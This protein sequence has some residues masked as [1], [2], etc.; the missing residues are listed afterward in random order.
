M[1]SSE[2][3]NS[4]KK[5][6]ADTGDA[7]G[8]GHSHGIALAVWALRVLCGAVFIF[9][10]WVK[11]IDPWGTVFKFNDYNQALGVSF[12]HELIVAGAFLLAAVEFALGVMLLTGAFKRLSAWAL[13][14]FMAVMTPLTAWIY[15]TDPVA[16][17][18]CF[19]DALIIS[20]GATFAKNLVL[21][22]AAVL[23]VLWNRRVKGI[24]KPAIQWV[25]LIFSLV[26]PLV[27]SLYGYTVQPLV[28]FRPFAVGEPVSDAAS[29]PEPRYIYSKGGV[30]QAFV[31]DSLPGDDEW[32]FVRRE[33]PAKNAKGSEIAIL[34]ADGDDIT[35]DLMD[36]SANGMMLLCVSEPAAHGISRSHM[37]NQLYTYLDY[38]DI[39]MV[40]V[41]A[42][43]SIDAWAAMV[44][45]QYPVYFADDTDI[46]TLVRGNAALVYV[47]NDTVQWKY[48]LYSIDP[49]LLPEEDNNPGD[50]VISTIT[51]VEDNNILMYLTMAYIAVIIVIVAMSLVRVKPAKLR[52]AEN[53]AADSH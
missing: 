12:P 39:P 45:A 34:D 51:P 46:K 31:A 43:D 53:K 40:A 5:N 52:K 2:S 19:G 8:A 27:L 13:A 29:V 26:Y 24:V 3:S 33:E 25:V 35:V 44:G 32:T 42:S 18:G 20:N 11:A 4:K 48:S 1:P 50:N 36:E 16:D 21:L 22:A 41:V 6:R 30:E 9:S 14:G 28:D 23:L 17:C 15:F 10:G 37:A 49:E 47:R 38:R 7:G